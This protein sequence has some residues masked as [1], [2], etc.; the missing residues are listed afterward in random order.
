[1]VREK[2]PLNS[3]ME[4]N[5]P[6][7]PSVKVGVYE[8]AD[9]RCES[10][11]EHLTRVQGEFHHFAKPR[12]TPSVETVQFLCPSCHKSYGHAIKVVVHRGLL[13]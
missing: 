7:S 13:R 12:V 4:G 8:R 11:G 10:C 2:V 5:K 1:M 6:I 3:G 9:G